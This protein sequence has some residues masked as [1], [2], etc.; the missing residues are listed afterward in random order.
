MRI[1]EID[2][3]PYDEQIVGFSEECVDTKGYINLYTTFG[4]EEGLNKIIKIRYLLINVNTS[5][6]ILLGCSSINHL[7]AIVSTPHLAMQFPS[8]TKDI[9]TVHVDQKT[10]WECYVASLRVEPTRRLY[11][12]SPCGRSL[13]RRE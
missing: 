2:I 13:R 11:K 6:S 1:P 5:Y 7:R 10:A 12:T 9:A 8:A 4:E 3:Q